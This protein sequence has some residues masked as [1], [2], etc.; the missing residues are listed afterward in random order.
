MIETEEMEFAPRVISPETTLDDG[1]IEVTLR[2]QT[3]SEYIGQEK[4]KDTLQFISKRQNAEMSRL[5]MFCFM[6]LRDL[7]KL[8]FRQLLLM[9]WA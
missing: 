5:T 8:P 9:K 7:A 4:V 1:D 3:L 2:P 6:G